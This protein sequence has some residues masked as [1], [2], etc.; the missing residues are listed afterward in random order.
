MKNL[1]DNSSGRK[2]FGI[3][4]FCRQGMTTKQDISIDNTYKVELQEVHRIGAGIKS[5]VVKY[6]NKPSMLL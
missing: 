6:Q 5:F 1:I 3:I 4:L 2:D